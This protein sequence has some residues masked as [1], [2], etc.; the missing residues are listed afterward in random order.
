M[1]KKQETEHT[2]IQDANMAPDYMQ[3]YLNI[4]D[5]QYMKFIKLEEGSGEQTGDICSNSMTE[6]DESLHANIQKY[7]SQ[8]D[9]KAGLTE[10]ERE[11][12]KEVYMNSYNNWYDPSSEEELKEYAEKNTMI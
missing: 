10:K 4:S 7:L 8:E 9:E 3:P 12:T 5:L 11:V 2:D 1:G 6:A